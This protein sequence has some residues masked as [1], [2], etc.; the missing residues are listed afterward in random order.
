MLSDLFAGAASDALARREAVSLKEL[1]SLALSVAPPLV[2]S[3]FLTHETHI[4][5]I[6]EIKRA[7][8]SKGNLAEIENPAELADSYV[9]GG[10]G[11]ISVLTETRRFLGN[12]EDLIAVRARVNV[13][14]LRKDFISN[15]YQILEARAHGADLVLLIAAGLATS[16]LV[17]LK[18][19]SEDLGMSVLMETHNRAEVELACEL[20][21]ELI[22]INAR[23]LET[24][25]TDRT[26]FGELA[27]LI[28]GTSIKIAESAIR[29]VDDVK[30]YASFGADCVLVGECLVTGDAETLVRSFSAVEKV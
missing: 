21:S 28:P 13:P 8:P 26:L 3:E 6:A 25:E 10:A 11:A 20:G 23:D 18:K 7:S 15:E 30:Q 12:L 24:F 2:V 5:V 22:G 27:S 29:N 17:S 1:E 4:R 14:V 19:F 9:R 16:S